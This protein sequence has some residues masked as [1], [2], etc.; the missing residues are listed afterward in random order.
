LIGV[1]TVSRCVLFVSKARGKESLTDIVGLM[2]EVPFVS[3]FARLLDE[4]A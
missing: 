3:E 4:P 2:P 1:G